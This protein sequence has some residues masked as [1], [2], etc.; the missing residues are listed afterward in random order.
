MASRRVVSTGLTE[1]EVSRLDDLAK[2][3]DVDRAELVRRCIR[4]GMQSYGGEGNE[5]DTP[6]F[7]VGCLVAAELERNDV[8]RTGLLRDLEAMQKE[9]HGGSE[10]AS[11]DL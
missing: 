5:L 1:L 8:L 9:L 4:K 7:R 6:S 3:L 10:V 2:E 11:A